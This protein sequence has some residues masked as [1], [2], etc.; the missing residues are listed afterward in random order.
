MLLTFNYFLIDVKQI[1][2]LST[3]FAAEPEVMGTLAKF[4]K[5]ERLSAVKK[6]K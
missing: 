2:Y 4:Q 3:L 6:D 1:I 5:Q